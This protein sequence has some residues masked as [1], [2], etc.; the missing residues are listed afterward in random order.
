MGKSDARKLATKYFTPPQ[1]FIA[2]KYFKQTQILL[3]NVSKL[4]FQVNK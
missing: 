1:C 3:L 4:V 2:I